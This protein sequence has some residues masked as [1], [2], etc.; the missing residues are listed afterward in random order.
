VPFN[1]A[2]ATDGGQPLEWRDY[3]AWKDPVP[4]GRFVQENVALSPRPVLLTSTEVTNQ[5][6][7]LSDHTA[8]HRNLEEFVGSVVERLCALSGWA[9]PWQR[10]EDI[11][12]IEAAQERRRVRVRTR[13]RTVT[14]MLVTVLALMA[15]MTFQQLS[16]LTSLGNAALTPLMG[17]LNLILSDSLVEDINRLLSGAMV[18]LLVIALAAYLWQRF[19][20]GAAWSQWERAEQSAMFHRIALRDGDAPGWVRWRRLA[21]ICAGAIMPLIVAVAFAVLVAR[22]T[23]L[24]G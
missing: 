24:G 11:A 9:S 19:V 5:Q 6:S 4:E 14:M 8:Y 18:G 3:L 1:F 20:A 12:V 22:G 23:I 13:G 10:A 17:L 2:T 15:F 16:A 7:V 21:F